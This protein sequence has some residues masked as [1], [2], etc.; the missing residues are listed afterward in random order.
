MKFSKLLIASSLVVAIALPVSAIAAPE[1]NEL[2][3]PI[4]ELMPH[5]K[6]MRDTLNLNEEQNNVIDAWIAEAPKKR[7]ALEQ[8]TIEVRTQLREALL[9]RDDR[10]QR[11][12]LKTILNAKNNRLVEMRSL[13]ARMLHKTLSANQ[14]AKVVDAY[15]ASLK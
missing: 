2:G 11:E 9:N 4:I 12:E 5:F 8:E 13:C 7:R 10:L 15:K 14:Y 3:A 1:R 6:K